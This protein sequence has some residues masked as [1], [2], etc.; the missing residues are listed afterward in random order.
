MS[1]SMLRAIAAG[2]IAGGLA[3]LLF[4]QGATSLLYHLVPALQEWLALPFALRPMGP[5]FSMLPVPPV[6][7]PLVVMA[8]FWG[9]VWGAVLGLLLSLME[10]G[11][12]LTGF[13]F[14]AVVCTVAGFNFAPGLRSLAVGSVSDAAHLVQVALV[15]GAWGWG[16]AGLLR[17]IALL[18]V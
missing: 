3:G 18:K 7:L 9:A 2:A 11:D 8:C 16:T 15:N 14:G 4:H 10:P 13:L 6:G 1:S 12:L 5:G 17:A